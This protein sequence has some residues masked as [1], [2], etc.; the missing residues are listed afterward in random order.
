MSSRHGI[1]SRLKKKKIKEVLSSGKRMDGRDIDQYR[2]ITINTGVIDKAEGSAQCNLGKSRVLVGVKIGIGTPFE[3]TPS[4]GV[5]ICNAEYTPVAHAT[6]EPGPP[7]ESSIELARVVDRGLRSA[8][9]I[10]FKKLALIPGKSVLMVYVD[11]YVLNYDG[12]LIDCASLAALAALKTSKMPVYKVNENEI[13][14]TKRKTAIKLQSMPLSVTFVKIGDHLLLDPTADEEDVMD[15]RLTISTDEKG[16]VCT[17]QK[18]GSE[19]LTMEE[20]QKS[21]NVAVEYAA[22][23]RNKI[24]GAD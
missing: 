6:F 21:I 2:E 11:I 14:L 5:L 22:K 13:E 7:D 9:I 4:K 10:D 19:G 1:V 23:N 24:M 3:D 18:S 20:I 15:M 12:N 17:I 16:N 8:E